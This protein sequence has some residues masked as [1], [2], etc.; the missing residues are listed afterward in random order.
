MPNQEK[1]SFGI[2]LIL[3]FARLPQEGISASIGL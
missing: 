3:T 2:A 1:F